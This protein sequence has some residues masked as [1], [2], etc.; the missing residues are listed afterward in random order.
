MINPLSSKKVW[1]GIG[2]AFWAIVISYVPFLAEYHEVLV[3]LT[4]L[5]AP[6]IIL[7][8]MAQDIAKEK[9]KS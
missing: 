5:V 6:A 3:E 9:Y 7:A 8:L 2:T 4:G 1:V